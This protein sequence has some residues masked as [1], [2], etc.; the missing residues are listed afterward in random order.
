MTG[1]VYSKIVIEPGT[2]QESGNANVVR[3][4]LTGL[5]ITST[6]P[7]ANTVINA[8]NN[9]NGIRIE[10]SGASVTG[11]TVKNASLEGILAEPPRSSWPSGPSAAPANISHVTIAGNVVTGNDRAYNPKLPPTAACPRSLTDA[12]DCGEGIHLL[13]VSSS[14]VAGN[15]VSH[16]VGGILASDGGFSIA[17]GPAAHNLIA[18]NHISDN[19]YDCGVTLPGHDPFAV[20]TSGPDA[21]KPQPDVAGVYD[22]E[23]IGNDSTGNGGA[24][25]LDAAPYPGDRRIR[26][27]LRRQ[28]GER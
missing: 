27:Y 22:N 17:V 18:G 6:G 1:T 24:G 26:Q 7:A 23:V 11:L 25:M 3:P 13:G 4:A 21:G 2:Y 10:A 5:R 9:A 15:D 28:H 20:A 12:D 14:T 19:R 8:S 16:N